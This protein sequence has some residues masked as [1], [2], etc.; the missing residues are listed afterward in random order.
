MTARDLSELLRRSAAS[1]PESSFVF[2]D[3]RYTYPEMDR[4]CDEF[5]AMYRSAGLGAG[6][7]IGLWMP[8]SLDMI[9]AIVACARIGAVAVPVN[10]RFRTDELQ[11]VVA[12]GD[13]TTLVTSAPDGHTDRPAELLRALPGLASAPGPVLHL[14]AAPRLRRVIVVGAAA[15]NYTPPGPGITG[16]HDVGLPAT[17]PA[18]RMGQLGAPGD[19]SHGDIAYLM[20]TSGTSASPKACIISAAAVVAQGGALADSRYLLDSDSAFWCP[21]P[22]FH[23][24]GLATLAACITAGASFVHAGVFDPTQSLRAMER[25]RVTH[26]IPCFETIWMRVLDHPDFATTDLSSLRVLMNTGG[27]DLLRKLQARVPHAV[28]LANYGITEGSGHVAMTQ[29]TDALDVRVRTGGFLLPGMQARIMDLETGQ[30]VAPNV[31][32]EIHFR[33]ESRFLG[34]YRDPEANATFIDADGWF[35]SGDLGMLDEDGRLTYKGRVKDMLKVGGENVASLEIE[36]YLLR[37]PDIAVAAVVA[38]PDAYY[39]EVPAAFVQLAD[40]RRLDEADVIDFCLDRIATYK[41]PRYVRFVTQWPMSGTKIRKVD[42]RQRIADE[43]TAQHITEA[44]RLR[45]SRAAR[46]AP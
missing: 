23:T 4:R 26:A 40:G 2:P 41:V 27:E 30:P 5:A 7:H 42:L 33:G 11:Y 15:Q 35:R 38:A 37:H 36:S 22:L 25:E 39:G 21:L 44:P 31:Q 13:L 32:G 29:T 6:D 45:S 18:Q 8:A 24:A 9:A 14:D 12:H 1:A 34:Y 43:L 19:E 16:Q 3:D 20:Y 10:D 46:V 17:H 28:Q